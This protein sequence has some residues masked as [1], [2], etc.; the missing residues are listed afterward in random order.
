MRQ[1]ELQPLK[2]SESHLSS[3]CGFG[4]Y[5]ACCVKWNDR[6]WLFVLCFSPFLSVSSQSAVQCARCFGLTS[7]PVNWRPWNASVVVAVTTAV[8]KQEVKT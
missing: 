5:V 4:D 7:D 3:L 8:E 6:M 2:V 1:S